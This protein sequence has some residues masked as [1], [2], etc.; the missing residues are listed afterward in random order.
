MRVERIQV[1]LSSEKRVSE[2]QLPNQQLLEQL[3]TLMLPA[4]KRACSQKIDNS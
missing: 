1:I 3:L 2:G 4:A